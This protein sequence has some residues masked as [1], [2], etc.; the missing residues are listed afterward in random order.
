MASDAGGS[1][2][3]TTS[4]PIR[5]PRSPLSEALVQLIEPYRQEATTLTAYK[6]LIGL[7]TLAWNL[8]SLSE[9]EREK[10][11]AEA[12]HGRDLPDPP[13]LREIVSALSRRKEHLF[14]YDRR[15]I[16]NCNVAIGPKGYH[17]TVVSAST[18]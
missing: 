1:A 15:L 17:V 14:P 12:T 6:A 8:T 2:S 7:A 13:M 4:R 10:Q 9:P 3:R 5:P 16:V 18:A 11:L